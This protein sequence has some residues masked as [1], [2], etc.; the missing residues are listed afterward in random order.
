MHAF[1]PDFHGGR[2]PSDAG[3][4]RATQQLYRRTAGVS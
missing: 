1:C 4:I 2:P 3:L